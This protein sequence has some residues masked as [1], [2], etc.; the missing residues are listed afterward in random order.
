MELTKEQFTENERRLA[1]ELEEELEVELDEE[2]APKKKKNQGQS[3][4]LIEAKSLSK[5]S[6]F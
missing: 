2:V 4:E 6:L 3:K 5:G 1:Q